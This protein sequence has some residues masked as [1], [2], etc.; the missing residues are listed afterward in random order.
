MSVKRFHHVT[1]SVFLQ[2]NESHDMLN[3]LLP[4]PLAEFFTIQH[5]NDPNQDRT[6]VYDLKKEKA[7]LRVQTAP[8]QVNPLTVLKIFFSKQTHTNYIFDTIFENITQEQRE[9]L[10][11]E[12]ML[13]V[14]EHGR[15]YLRLEKKAFSQGEFVLTKGGD[16]IHLAFSLAAYPKNP[17]TI[18]NSVMEL[19]T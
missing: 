10:K 19:F 17:K 15:F 14:D 18:H 8:D 5:H 9:A 7:D 12:A 6:K 2:E 1:I 4:F 16:C 3:T 13:H 11:S